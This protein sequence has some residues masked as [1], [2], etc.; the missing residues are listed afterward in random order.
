MEENLEVDKDYKEAFNQG[1]ELAKQLK[2]TSPMFKTPNLSSIGRMKAV[3]EG[4]EQYIT[5]VTAKKKKNIAKNPHLKK[6]TLKNDRDKGPN[7]SS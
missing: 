6:S 1:Y 7:L 3:Q 2:L 5:E 4:M